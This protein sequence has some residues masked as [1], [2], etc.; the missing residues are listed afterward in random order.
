MLQ[1]FGID[2]AGKWYMNAAN[3]AVYQMT[4]AFIIAQYSMLY[5]STNTGLP[6]D[7]SIAGTSLNRI[8]HDLMATKDTMPFLERG[9][10]QFC[11]YCEAVDDHDADDCPL[12]TTITCIYCFNATGPKNAKYRKRAEGHHGGRCIL[13]YCHHTRKI[14]AWLEKLD[15]PIEDLRKLSHG[16]AIMDFGSI[17]EVF[18]DSVLNTGPMGRADEGMFEAPNHS[19]GDMFEASDCD[20]ESDTFHGFIEGEVE[21]FD[22][23]SDDLSGVRDEFDEDFDDNFD[24]NFEGDWEGDSEEAA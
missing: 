18:Y 17:G 20:Y 14:P 8:L 15:L 2:L 3:S 19:D 21:K 7:S 1:K 23:E 13:R 9:F 16:M 22:D 12:R 4:L 5:P 10:A 24:D 6:T 11:F